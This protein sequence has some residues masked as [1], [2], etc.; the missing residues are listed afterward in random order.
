MLPAI[1]GFFVLFTLL[2]VPIAFGLA[3]AIA[4]GLVTASEV[5]LFVVAHKMATGID[6][7]VL[8]AIPLYILAGSLMETGG[9]SVRLVA[10][11]RVLVGWIR[12]GL[13]MVVVVVEYLF[14]GLSGSTAA[15]VSAV[16]SMLIPS[17][18]R[19]GYSRA[20]AVSVVSASSAMG[21]L[22]PPC[23]N[24]VVAGA[25]ANVSVGALF[26]GGFIPAM[27]LALSILVLIYWQARRYGW[28]A[29]ERV[30]AAK[31]FR[32]VAGAILPMGMPVIIFGGI[33]GG[34]VTPTEAGMLA[35]V[36]ALIVGIVVYREIR[37]RDLYKI[38]LDAAVTS[39]VV[40]ILVGVASVFAWLMAAEAVPAAILTGMLA[41][42][43]SPI[44]FLALSALIFM[45]IGAF[46]EGLPAIVVLLP[47]M[48]P[49]VG[50]LGIDPI[51]YINVVIAAV[52]IG[53]FLPPIGLGLFIACSIAKISVT[54]GS[55]A[56]GPF[57][58]ML[59]LGLLVI[60]LVPSL[61]L[62]LP[63]LTGLAR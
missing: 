14:S 6:S 58:L 13:A 5:P 25:I 41:I 15:D 42:S 22:V 34:I 33:L 3:V 21:M 60:I 53:L 19:A 8:L 45:I 55:R 26:I 56:L 39:G 57:L 37:V 52:G 47:T 46:L 4:L 63:R 35:V 50:K 49:I 62:L 31:F 24:M 17:M 51:H 12:G 18:H 48:Y 59:L 2:D 36:Y 29:E 61:T 20:Y 1:L 44:V 54:E 32:A 16:G 30:T 23:I 9:I 43:H 38:L 40:A 10:L 27:V 11:A 28:A 7:F